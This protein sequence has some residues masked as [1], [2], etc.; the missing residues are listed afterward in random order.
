MSYSK[1]GLVFLSLAFLS[2]N[3]AN[4]KSARDLEDIIFDEHK[5]IDL[6]FSLI[7]PGRHLSSCDDVY[8]EID[9]LKNS[10]A[11]CEDYDPL[12]YSEVSDMCD[13]FYEQLNIAEY[14]YTNVELMDPYLVRDDSV[15][16]RLNINENVL[17]SIKIELSEIF[18]SPER[19]IWVDV[20]AKSEDLSIKVLDRSSHF[21]YIA[22]LKYFP[23]KV[24]YLSK[25]F[26][27]GRF[28]VNG[29]SY[30]C[31]LQ[32]GKARLEL[33]I[34]LI[35][36]YSQVLPSKEKATYWRLYQ[37]LLN[38]M[39]HQSWTQE[40]QRI[41]VAAV[42]AQRLK[43]KSVKAIFFHEKIINDNDIKPRVIADDNQLENLLVARKTIEKTIKAHGVFK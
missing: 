3:N 11:I 34:D 35:V 1:T 26:Q 4:A 8:K 32:S 40:E 16:Y 14:G 17:E 30:N 10:L 39:F 41:L 24:D 43:K 38:L 21:A 6:S 12:K 28:I 31:A 20:Q 37:D 33:P 19:N 29:R 5:V 22:G 7:Y 9:A 18:T 13:Y 36:S 2:A 42:V 23:A 27:D 25:N 15:S